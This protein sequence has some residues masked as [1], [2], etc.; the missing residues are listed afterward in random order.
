MKKV[1]G[2]ALAFYVGAILVN[3]AV[4]LLRQSLPILIPIGVAV[5]ALTIYIRLRKFRDQNNN[6]Y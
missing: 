4:G 3:M 5:I 2:Y 1:L 6:R